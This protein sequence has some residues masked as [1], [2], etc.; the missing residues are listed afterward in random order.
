MGAATRAKSARERANIAAQM[1]RA[2]RT[3]TR[4][5]DD[6][7]EMYD[8]DAVRTYLLAK[9]VTDPRIRAFAE[10]CRWYSTEGN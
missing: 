1:I 7:F 9:A 6:C 10:R 2:G 4:A 5:F 8:G 3:H